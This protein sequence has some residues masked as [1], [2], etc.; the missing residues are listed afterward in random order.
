MAYLRTQGLIKA[1]K[2][3]PSF[4]KSA[5]PLAK[6]TLQNAC[7]AKRILTNIELKARRLNCENGFGTDPRWCTEI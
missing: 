6:E 3:P 7:K 5:Q 4:G 1:V 2:A